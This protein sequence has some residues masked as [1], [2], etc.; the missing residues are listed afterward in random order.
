MVRHA[1]Q[2]TRPQRC[3]HGREGPLPEP[4]K[5][6][7]STPYDFEGRNLTAYG[8]LLP[9]ATMLEKLEFQRVVE[10]TL[11]VKRVTRVMSLYR[12]VLAMVLAL[13]VGFSRLPHLRFLQRDPRLVGILK[14]LGLPPPCTFWRFLASR[15]LQIAPQLLEGQRRM[16]PRVWEAAPARLRSATLDTNTTVHTLFPPAEGSPQSLQPAA[17]GEEE[18]PA[19]ADVLC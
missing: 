8:G 14:V 15:H 10:E 5:I 11:G 2:D 16:R 12:F 19:P 9:V 18:L 4:N 13:Y 1:S 6:A 17:P 3:A 7:A